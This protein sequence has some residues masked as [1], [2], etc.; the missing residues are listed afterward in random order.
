M[1]SKLDQIHGFSMVM[2]S[3]NS[4]LNC[5]GNGLQTTPHLNP[6]LKSHGS[7]GSPQKLYAL[8]GDYSWMVF[9]WHPALLLDVLVNALQ[10]VNYA[11]TQKKMGNT[12]V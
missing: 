6:I 4:P 8:F 2:P 1:F 9:K 12:Y 3:G 5:A 7:N 10:C 11:E